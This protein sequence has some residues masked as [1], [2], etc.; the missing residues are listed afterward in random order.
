M[1]TLLLSRK[2]IQDLVDVRDGIEAVEQTFRGMS[3][4]TVVNPPKVG[5]DLGET[6]DYPPYN[7]LI[8]AMPAYVGWL[9]SAGLK[10]VGGFRDNPRR[11]LPFISSTILLSDPRTGQLVAVMDGTFVTNLRTGGQTAVA[12]K[13]LHA[14]PTVRLGLYGAGVQARAQTRA[15]AEVT[16]IEA[17]TVYDIESRTAE[18]FASEMAATVAGKIRVAAAPEDVPANAEVVLCVTQSNAKFFRK[19]WYRPGMLLLPMGSFQECDD[20]CILAADK[21]VVDHAEQC[22][23]RGALKQLGQAGRVTAAMIYATLAEI[24]AERK[25]GRSAPDERLLC[26]TIGTGAMDVAV[27]SVAYRR[28]QARGVGARYAFT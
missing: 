3:D 7:G 21:I 5:L 4:S 22:L 1:E 10:W 20:A 26:V 16:T 2:E 9:D 18:T 23:H 14:Q 25:P 8:N 27:A 17:L 13:Y 11:G 12:V 24:V 6:A 15:I 19:A 28:A